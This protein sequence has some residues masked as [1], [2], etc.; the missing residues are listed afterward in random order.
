MIKNFRSDDRSDHTI[1]LFFFMNNPSMGME[2][3]VEKEKK[4]KK[5]NVSFLC[6]TPS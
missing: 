1:A 3:T 4:R 5:K 2:K 6:Y